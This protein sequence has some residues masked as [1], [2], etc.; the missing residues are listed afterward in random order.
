MLDNES[1][2]YYKTRSYDSRIG[3]WASKQ[4]SILKK[5]EELYKLIDDYKK[6]YPDENNV[7]RPDDWSGWSL[8]P[9]SFEFWLDGK[10]RIHQR[11]KYTKKENGNWERFLLNP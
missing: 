7:P 2:K 1:D 10:N 3:A 6:K 5:R 11:L 9:N 4:S 8:K